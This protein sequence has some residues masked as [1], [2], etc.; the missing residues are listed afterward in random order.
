MWRKGEKSI[1]GNMIDYDTLSLDK[2]LIKKFESWI[3]A[4]DDAFM[5]LAVGDVKTANKFA[6][7]KVNQIGYGL[8]CTLKRLF[9]NI[10]IVFYSENYKGKISKPITIDN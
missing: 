5:K 7:E 4:Y 10:S 9:P 1:C 6:V 2:K 8:A 3:N